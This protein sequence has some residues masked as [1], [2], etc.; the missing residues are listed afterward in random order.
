MNAAL[1]VARRIITYYQVLV[2]RLRRDE[3]PLRG[4]RVSDVDVERGVE[5]DGGENSEGEKGERQSREGTDA[6]TGTETE[7]EKGV[8]KKEV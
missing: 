7:T 6:A 8:Q 4:E 5:R 3:E 1:P 2:W